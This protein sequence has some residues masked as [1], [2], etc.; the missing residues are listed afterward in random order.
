M[1]KSIIVAIF[2]QIATTTAAVTG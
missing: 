2:E 1:L